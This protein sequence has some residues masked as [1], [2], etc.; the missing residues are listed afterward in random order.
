MQSQFF[1]C[2]AIVRRVRD[3]GFEFV[4]GI[5]FVNE[6]ALRMLTTKRQECGACIPILFDK[7]EARLMRDCYTSPA[8]CDLTL[9]PYTTGRKRSKYYIAGFA[10]IAGRES[11]P[12]P[13]PLAIHAG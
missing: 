11:Y 6:R 3:E 1:A 13:L 9:G 7:F 2:F 4:S 12:F 8:V 5:R 10:A